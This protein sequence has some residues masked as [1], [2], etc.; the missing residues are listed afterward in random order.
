M[1]VNDGKNTIETAFDYTFEVNGVIASLKATMDPLGNT[2]QY[3][4]VRV[5]PGTSYKSSK[6][7]GYTDYFFYNLTF[8]FLLPAGG[9]TSST[10][11]NGLN[12][13]TNTY[14]AS[15]E[16]VSSIKNVYSLFSKDIIRSDNQ[17]K[18]DVSYFVRQTHSDQII[19]GVTTSIDYTY[20]LANGLLKTQRQ[21][22]LDTESYIENE[23][24]YGYEVY[25]EL[26]SK[27]IYSPVVKTKKTINRNGRTYID[28]VSV[29]TWKPWGPQAVWSPHKTY[30]WRRKRIEDQDDSF[31]FDAWSGDVEV[32][33]NSYWKLIL[34]VNEIDNKG[35]VIQSTTY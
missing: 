2:A 4:A 16:L 1:L 9:L 29:T 17:K 3:H 23:T 31:Q 15:G 24:T 13:Q 30:Q 6:P 5:I 12:Y 25:S 35:N 8:D 10:L 34:K 27:N 7:N 32:P 20:N 21:Y 14:N 22:Q 11:F 28:N 26:V 19:D 33:L 18:V